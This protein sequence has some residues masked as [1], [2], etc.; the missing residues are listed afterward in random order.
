VPITH[1]HFPAKVIAINV[2]DRSALML[3]GDRLRWYQV[4][5]LEGIAH[6]AES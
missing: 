6:Q 1:Y 5:G 3:L 4:I 2:I